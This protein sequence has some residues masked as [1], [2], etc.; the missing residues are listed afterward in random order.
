MDSL[1]QVL[2]GASVAELVIGR[3]IG[4]KASLYG[5]VLG[6][7]PDLDVLIPYGGPIED[8]TYHRGFSHSLLVLSAAAP[9]IGWVLHRFQGLASLKLWIAMAWLVLITH[10]LLDG[11]TVYGTQLFWPVTE[12]PVSGSSVFII[13]PAVTVWLALGVIGALVCSRQR[14]TGYRLNAIGLAIACAYLAWAVAAKVHVTAIAAR[15]LDK[16][17][18]AYTG[19][20][21]TPAPFNTLLWRFVAMQDDGYFVGYYSVFDDTSDIQ[22]TRYESRTDLLAPLADNWHVRRLQWFSHGFYRVSQP[23]R[24]ELLITDLRMGVEDA[25]VFRFKVADI[26][27]DGSMEPANE[28]IPVKRVTSRL[29]QFLYRIWDS[30]VSLAPNKP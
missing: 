13:D 6:T 23:S 15:S 11:F 9:A 14:L 22:F 26:A 17:G 12:Y 2:L 21:S 10:P 7:L 3:A 5:A 8:F 24:S 18:I 27:A 20:L 1:T 28:R 25:Y 30:S 29:W 19:L 16:Q 4:R